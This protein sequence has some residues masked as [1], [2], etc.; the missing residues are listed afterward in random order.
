MTFLFLLQS[1]LLGGS[2]WLW[3]RLLI[4]RIRGNPWGQKV[5]TPRFRL[6]PQWNLLGFAVGFLVLPIGLNGYFES[7]SVDPFGRIQIQVA[8][9]LLFVMLWCLVQGKIA[10]AS[11]PQKENPPPLKLIDSL[12]WG[13]W[14]F[15]LAFLPV[16]LLLL[17]V[18]PHRQAHPLIQLLQ[19]HP[20]SELWL[21]VIVAAVAAAP[22]FEEL[23]FRVMLQSC[24]TEAMDPLQAILL[25]SLI[26]AFSHG[27][28]DAIPLFPLALILGM[29]F[30][31]T[32]SYWA[33]VTAHALFN[34]CNLLMFWQGGE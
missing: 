2:A 3:V 4:E 17:V 5:G 22:L 20:T 11:E 23:L 14:G 1:G 13:G 10:V 6:S 16:F 29:L 27:E 26:F 21:T 28:I 33:V 18:E 30:Q 25:S 7:R 19:D 24:L 31:R 34:G 32:G 12:R 15:L 8:A 9:R